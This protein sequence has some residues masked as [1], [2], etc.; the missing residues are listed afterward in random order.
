MKC[1][2]KVNANPINYVFRLQRTRK[3]PPHSAAR[4]FFGFLPI[5]LDFF[6]NG[7][8]FL[9]NFFLRI[10]WRKKILRLQ[11]THKQAH[12]ICRQFL[13][14]FA[15]E[16]K[17]SDISHQNLEQPKKSGHLKHCLFQTKWIYCFCGHNLI[18][19]LIVDFSF[20]AHEPALHLF[21]IAGLPPLPD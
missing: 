10:S 8:G 11:R 7:Y 5:F 13:H 9:P 3:P 12:I 6:S 17:R 1:K 19:N 20:I 16:T 4:F 14:Q 15:K 21:A 18:P 2:K